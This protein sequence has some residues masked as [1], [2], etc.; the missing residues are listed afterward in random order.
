MQHALPDTTIFTSYLIKLLTMPVRS[1]CAL[2]FN[3]NLLPIFA[4]KFRVP[5]TL[6]PW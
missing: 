6:K 1:H 4:T 2:Q 5:V 3:Q